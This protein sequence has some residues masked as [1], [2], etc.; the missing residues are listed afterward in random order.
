LSVNYLKREPIRSEFRTN[1]S[2]LEKE[3]GGGGGI[4][5][6]YLKKKTFKFVSRNAAKKVRDIFEKNEILRLIA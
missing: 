1:C 3:G 5:T 2:A 6:F 4:Q